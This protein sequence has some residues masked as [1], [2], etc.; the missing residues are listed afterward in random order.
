[1][2]AMIATGIELLHH[3][4]AVAETA[5]CLALLHPAPQP[6]MRLHREV[7]QEERV[8]RALEPDMKLADLALCQRHNGDAREL[9][10]LVE[11]GDIGLIAADP[12][13]CLGKQDIELAVLPIPHQPL[14][15][16]TQD[17]A[18]PRDRRI[19][20]GTDDLPPLPRRMFPAQ[21]ELVLDGCLALLGLLS[22]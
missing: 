20:V 10:M 2:V 19:L 16:R 3:F 12:V 21:P 18:A 6:A 1:M 13:Q 11:R 15:A 9:Q 7:F 4:V 22:E 8:H 14:N 5:A 17:R